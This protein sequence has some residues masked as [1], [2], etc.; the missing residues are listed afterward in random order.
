MSYKKLDLT[1]HIDYMES[2]IDAFR[3][4]SN[5]GNIQGVSDLYKSYKGVLKNKKNMINMKANGEEKS[6]DGHIWISC[7]GTWW[8]HTA[9]TAP[10]DGERGYATTASGACGEC[11]LPISRFKT[12][13][14]IETPRS[15]EEI[16]KLYVT[17]LNEVNE[18][19]WLKFNQTLINPHTAMQIHSASP[20]PFIATHFG[21]AAYLS[22]K[23]DIQ[24][25]NVGVTCIIN[26]PL[27]VDF[28]AVRIPEDTRKPIDRG[29]SIG[30]PRTIHPGEPIVINVENIS[31]GPLVFRGG[32]FGKFVRQNYEDIPRFPKRMSDD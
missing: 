30:K 10:V 25:L 28:Y 22:G 21:V 15:E 20:L 5:E 8:S 19:E 16:E 7:C 11:M 14:S 27:P 32:M 17:R 4:A 9:W 6:L 29:G 18:G 24:S 26:G 2:Y 12:P 1:G 31:D 13:K 23:I 3:K